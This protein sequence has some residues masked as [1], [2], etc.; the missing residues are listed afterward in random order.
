MSSGIIFQDLE[1]SRQYTS[2]EMFVQAHRGFKMIQRQ[3]V[4]FEG[5]EDL[6][7]PLAFLIVDGIK[8]PR[9]KIFINMMQQTDLD[10]LIH[11]LISKRAFWMISSIEIW[12][13]MSGNNVL[14]THKVGLFLHEWKNMIW[15]LASNQMAQ[16]LGDGQQEPP[17]MQMPQLPPPTPMGIPQYGP[18]PPMQLPQLPPPTPMK[19]PQYEPPAPQPQDQSQEIVPMG[20]ATDAPAPA[21]PPSAAALKSAFPTIFG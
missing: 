5:A 2:V 14:K 9:Y 19:I 8:I 17:P 3:N 18:P 12:I 4:S 20:P 6:N 21:S 13:D 16:R 10:P 7:H 1:T 11:F 15:Q